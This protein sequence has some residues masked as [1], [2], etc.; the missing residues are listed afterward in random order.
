MVSSPW[1]ERKYYTSDVRLVPAR[2]DSDP[3]LAKTARAA[4]SNNNNVS[5]NM[6]AVDSS[7]SKEKVDGGFARALAKQAA[8]VA[9]SSSGSRG[10]GRLPPPSPRT[11]RGS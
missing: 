1:S 11:V 6:K 5:S 9:G 10:S 4:D 7:T 2:R 8:A 3:D